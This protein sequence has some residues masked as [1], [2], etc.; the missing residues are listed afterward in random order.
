M[1]FDLSFTLHARRVFP[2]AAPLRPRLA[3]GEERQRREMNEGRTVAR[4]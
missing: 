2:F 4:D 1:S 3:R